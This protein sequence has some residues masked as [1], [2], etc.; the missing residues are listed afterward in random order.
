[1]EEEASDR[2]LINTPESSWYTPSAANAILPPV[3]YGEAPAGLEEGFPADPLVAGQTYEL[4]LWRA[5]PEAGDGAGCI[6]TFEHSEPVSPGE[7][8]QEPQIFCLLAVH[9]FTT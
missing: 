3:T 2:W 4:V 8:A 1:M 6:M 9:E 5:P 7:P